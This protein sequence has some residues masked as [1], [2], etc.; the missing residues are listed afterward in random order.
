MVMKIVWFG[1]F[2]VWA[3]P[4]LVACGGGSSS[5]TDGMTGI[6]TGTLSSAPANELEIG[7]ALSEPDSSAAEPVPVDSSTD[8][9][10]RISS[11][12]VREKT[13]VC[14][15]TSLE[16]LQ[17]CVA[18]A[19]SYGGLDI[20]SDLSC[21]NGNCCHQS[22]ALVTLRGLSG[23]TIHG[24]SHLLRRESDQRQCGLLDIRNSNNVV[25]E[26][27]Y[28]D[29]DIDAPGCLVGESC[30]RMLFI[31]DSKNVTLDNVNVSNGKGYNI[32]VNGVEKFVFQNSSLINS[33]ILGLYVG[34]G[35]NYSSEVVIENSLF[36]DIQTNAIALLGIG[37]STTNVVRNNTFFRNHR[38]GH[39]D[40]NPRFGTGT[41]GGGQVYIAR[42]SN[43]LIEDN[44]ILDGYCDNCYVSEGNRT[45]IHGIELGEPNRA[46]LSNIDIRDNTIGNHDGSGIYLNNGNTIDSSIRI[47][48]NV[49]FNNTD[50]VQKKLYDNG[51]SIGTNDDRATVYFESFESAEVPGN[52]FTISN[53]CASESTVT[54]VC[55]GESLH[56]SCKV[57]LTL[58][59]QSCD[60]ANVALESAWYQL[61]E[62]QRTAANGW[63]V[64]GG[65]N[66]NDLQLGDW[67][68]E[69]SDSS[70]VITGIECREIQAN[71]SSAQSIHGLP[72][73]DVV[74]PTGSSQ[75]RWVAR[76]RSSTP[77]GIDDLKLTGVR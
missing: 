24:N 66:S 69:F 48:N 29:D 5:A 37:G 33:G 2:A 56:G 49:L 32:Y 73:I 6:E 31:G 71:D 35:D 67:C 4:V 14:E 17:G 58:D 21:S 30:S 70:G 16:T 42:A 60:D 62:G 34:H 53:F 7:A 39:W 52:K 74:A 59:G 25:V 44:T 15:V 11:P 72:S 45:G 8:E 19:S 12:I 36:V 55:S 3:L 68:L 27:W 64:G 54:K 57:T 47:S 77:F 50:G 13:N 10:E 75:V 46:S 63:V 65:S 76:N 20:K 22:G 51:A 40:V 26:N 18:N 9:P 41:T 28:L 43:V 1:L 23:F 61:I 38:H